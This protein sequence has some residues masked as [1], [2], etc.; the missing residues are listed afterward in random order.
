MKKWLLLIIPA[1]SFAWCFQNC[2]GSNGTNN[3]AASAANIADTILLINW[4]RDGNAT[5]TMTTLNNVTVIRKR[6]ATPDMSM[7][8]NM[9][10]I[11]IPVRAGDELFFTKHGKEQVHIRMDAV[12]H[13]TH[14]GVYLFPPASADR[15]TI[16]GAVMGRN[17]MPIGQLPIMIGTDTLSTGLDGLYQKA[18]SIDSIFTIQYFR[19][20]SKTEKNAIITA[21]TTNDGGRVVIDVAFDDDGMLGSGG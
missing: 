11:Q 14:I 12:L 4:V 21:N 9:Q 10:P 1:F 20:G 5:G 18:V 6:S 2:G 19:S 13:L 7:I 8:Y 16:G 3:D 17:N 15:E